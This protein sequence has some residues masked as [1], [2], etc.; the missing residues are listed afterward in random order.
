MSIE[1]YSPTPLDRVNPE[2]IGIAKR[3]SAYKQ[4]RQ[5]IEN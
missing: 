2:F 4:K 1:L 5:K 3:H